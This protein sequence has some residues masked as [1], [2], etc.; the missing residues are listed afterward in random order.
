[1]NRTPSRWFA[2]REAMLHNTPMRDDIDRFFNHFFNGMMTPWMPTFFRND[3]KEDDLLPR[4]DLTS[5]DK[6]Y[7]LKVE[8][9]GVEPED[10]KLSVHD[11][12][13][14]IS[15]E[16]KCET[17]DKEKHVTERSFGSFQRS[18]SL[19]EDADVDAITAAHKNG[20]L[21][22]AIPRLAESRNT[23]KIIAIEK[24]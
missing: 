10:V 3:R 21:S 13:L 12:I 4:I 11:G 9:P 5:D 23:A 16:K 8:V 17:E 15:G 24:A 7:T 18:M 1:M 6:A 19:P 14:E 22:V 2:P 20:V